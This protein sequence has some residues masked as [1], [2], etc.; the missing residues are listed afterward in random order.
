MSQFFGRAFKDVKLKELPSFLIK[1]VVANPKQFY[2]ERFI[3]SFRGVYWSKDLINIARNKI[4]LE[5]AVKQKFRP[6]GVEFIFF[7][8]VIGTIPAMY[9]HEK[10]HPMP[11]NNYN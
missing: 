1:E 5:E 11:L 10:R 7:Y 9:F 6:M 2:N 4:P 8:V 3:T